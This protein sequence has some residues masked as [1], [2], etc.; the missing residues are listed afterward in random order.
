MLDAYAAQSVRRLWM[1]LSPLATPEQD[2]SFVEPIMS[3]WC[4][5]ETEPHLTSFV[6]KH[7]A[8][9]QEDKGACFHFS[10]VPIKTQMFA[11]EFTRS[12]KF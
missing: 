11:F 12:R 9:E 2:S 4:F 1:T 3:G 6:G 7:C 8:A 10:K 5:T